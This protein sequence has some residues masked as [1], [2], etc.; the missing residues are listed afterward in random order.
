MSING[1]RAWVWTRWCFSWRVG[2]QSRARPSTPHLTLAPGDAPPFALCPCV[3][4]RTVA[5]DQRA[6]VQKR[7]QQL[8]AAKMQVQEQAEE[9]EPSK[10]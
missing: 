7:R 2:L 9:E 3:G 6:D 5:A 8:A 4:P 1:R 10:V